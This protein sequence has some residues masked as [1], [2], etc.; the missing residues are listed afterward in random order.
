MIEPAYLDADVALPDGWEWARLGDVSEV[1]P[2]RASLKGRS[3]EALTTFI[4]MAAVDELS[5]TVANAQARAFRDVRTGYTYFENGDVL[6]AKI[7]PCMRNGKQAVATDLID[8][9][10]FGTTEFH[11]FR[12]SGSITSAWL[13]RFVR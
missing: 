10:G 2:R 8:G 1:N 5:G 6:F 9:F 12:P 11:V 4:P 7:T 13:H 3:D